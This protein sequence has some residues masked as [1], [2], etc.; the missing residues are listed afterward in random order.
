MWLQVH[1]KATP[2]PSQVDPQSTK[3]NLDVLKE[4]N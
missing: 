1:E 2:N 4:N 3:L